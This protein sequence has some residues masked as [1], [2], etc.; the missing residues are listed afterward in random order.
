[1][2]SHD[3]EYFR[4]SFMIRSTIRFKGHW[5]KTT[6]TKFLLIVIRSRCTV[7][8]SLVVNKKTKLPFSIKKSLSAVLDILFVCGLFAESKDCNNIPPHPTPTLK[9][10]RLSARPL[11]SYS[12]T[13]LPRNARLTALQPAFYSSLQALY[14]FPKL[15]C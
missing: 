11:G 10:G 8:L 5:R 3:C 1:M 7:D 12:S 13:R 6:H 14:N 15:G 9:R 4:K 2:V